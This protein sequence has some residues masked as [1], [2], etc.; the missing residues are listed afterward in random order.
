VRRAYHL[1]TFLLM[2][3]AVSCTHVQQIRDSHLGTGTAAEKPAPS[4]AAK[5]ER[6]TPDEAK[7][8]LAQAV[9]HYNSVGQKQALADFTERKAP[10]YDRDLYVFCIGQ[11]RRTTANG[12]FPQYV[13]TSVDALKDADGKPLGRRILDVVSSSG[14]GSVEYDWI[15]PMNHKTEHKIAFAKKVGDDVCGVGAYNPE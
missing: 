12:G 4:S 3:L 11:N 9:E 6:G 1:M 15:N 8:M 7:A 14:E 10:F 13:G 5:S 2:G